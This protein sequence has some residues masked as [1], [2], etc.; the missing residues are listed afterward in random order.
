MS[1]TL[2]SP[3]W[4]ETLRATPRRIVHAGAMAAAVIGFVALTH[5]HGIGS[6]GIAVAYGEAVRYS[7]APA[8]LGRVAHLLVHVGQQVHAGEPLAVLDGRELAAERDTAR[9]ALAQL[10]AKVVAQIQDE[11]LQVTR[12]E[13]SLLK[14]RAAERGDRA[15]LEEIGQ[16]VKRL[17]ELLAQQMITASAA[18]NARE[19]Q[20][21]LAARVSTFDEA[22][23][24]GQAGLSDGEARARDHGRAVELHVEPARRAVQVQEALLRQ[25]DLRTEQLTLRAPDDGTVT[26]LTHRPGEIVS[27]GTEVVALVCGRADV[28]LAQL[29]EGM[30]DRVSVGQRVTVRPKDAWSSARYGHIVELA[31]EVDEMPVRARPSPAISAWGRRATVQLDPGGGQVLP[32]QAFSVSLD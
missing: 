5:G 22:R 14:A 18:E 9:A 20:Q 13:L 7:V 23:L 31:P 4:L 30:A 21:L 19:T 1:F 32:G 8:E 11:E 16:R 15:Q 10:E 24:H 25:L 6:S 17:D 26:W 3:W 27:A 28:V 2:F 29:P 12:S